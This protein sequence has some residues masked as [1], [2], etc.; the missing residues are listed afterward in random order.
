VRESNK[1]SLSG[2]IRLPRWSN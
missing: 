1:Y 2:H